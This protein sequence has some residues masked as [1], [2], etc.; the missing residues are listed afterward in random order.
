MYSPYKL[1][2][3]VVINR[4]KPVLPHL[5]V[6]NQTSFVGGRHIMDNVVIAQ[7][8]VHLMQIKKGKRRWM[9]IKIDMEKAYDRLR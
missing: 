5:V 1:L 9:A 2:T 6:E 3:K 8:V 4:L 7:E